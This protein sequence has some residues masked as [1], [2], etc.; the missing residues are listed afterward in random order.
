M[1]FIEVLSEKEFTLKYVVLKLGR[2]TYSTRFGKTPKDASLKLQKTK[3]DLGGIENN[4]W[5]KARL[6]EEKNHQGRMF[7]EPLELNIYFVKK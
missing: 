4:F 1:G 7:S 5:L 3:S 6:T 2:R